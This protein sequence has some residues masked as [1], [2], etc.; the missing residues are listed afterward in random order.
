[1]HGNRLFSLL[2][3]ELNCF[4]SQLYFFPGQQ[5]GHWTSTVTSTILITER[6]CGVMTVAYELRTEVKSILYL[7]GT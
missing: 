5:H 1:M 3:N 4:I 7:I 6:M 2:V